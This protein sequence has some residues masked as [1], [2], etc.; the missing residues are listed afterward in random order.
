M[1]STPLSLSIRRVRPED[2]ALAKATRL[3][4]L[5]TDPLSFS[6]TYASE[7]V[8]DDAFWE[9]TA[10]EHAVSDDRAIFLAITGDVVVGLV[11]AGR[12]PHQRDRFGIYS[13]WVAPSARGRGVAR[14][15]LA[16]AEEFARA[17]G[18]SQTEL[19]VSDAAPTARR[20]YDRAGYVPD[21]HTSETRPGVVERRL[22]KRL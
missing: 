3:R 1:A 6:S 2:A 16:T 8:R 9:A 11:R 21:G 14:A 18:G 15:L 7:I 22:R 13:M 5:A 12:D 20:L 19:E 10:A 17:R 4:A